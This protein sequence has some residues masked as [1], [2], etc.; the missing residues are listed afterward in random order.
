MFVDASRDLGA[1]NVLHYIIIEDDECFLLLLYGLYLHIEMCP[2]VTIYMM[3]MMTD[4]EE[5]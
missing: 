2:Q 1:D 5:K 3:F 4:Y